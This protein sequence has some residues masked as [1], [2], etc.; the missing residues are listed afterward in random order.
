[1]RSGY[2]PR[3][4]HDPQLYLDQNSY[5]FTLYDVSFQAA[6]HALHRYGLL[7]Q[8]SHVAWSVCLYVCVLVTRVCCAKTAEPIEMPFGRL[9]QVS[10]GTGVEIHNWKRQFWEVVRS[11]EKHWESAAVYTTNGII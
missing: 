1:M 2:L 9:T 6:S 5:V 11:I 10:Q 7:L 3:A 8:M 4:E